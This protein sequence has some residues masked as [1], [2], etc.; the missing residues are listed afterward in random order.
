MAWVDALKAGACCLIVLHHLAFYG[1]MADQAS[2][3]WPGMF[4]WLAQHA[5]LA[6]Q[7]FL[8]LGGYLAARSLLP[9]L[10]NHGARSEHSG[11]RGLGDSFNHPRSP[12]AHHVSPWANAVERIAQRFIRLALPLWMALVAAVVCNAWADHWMDHPSIG[13]PPQGDQVLWHLLLL[14]DIA[15]HEALSAGVWYVAIDFQLYALLTL[16]AAAAQGTRQARTTLSVFCLLLLAVSAGWFNR[17]AH[18]D[19]FAPY[20]WTAYGLGVLLGLQAGPRTWV[21]AAVI[22]GVAVWWDPRL[23]LMVAAGTALVIGMAL[24]LQGRMPLSVAPWVQGLSR[25]SYSVFLIHFPI[26]LVVNA[27]WTAFLPPSPLVQFLGVITAFKLSLLAGWIFHHAV[28][29]PLVEAAT[30]LWR[31]PRSQVPSGSA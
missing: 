21:A 10:R 25:I 11:S 5:R 30:A 12:G 4:E 18:L 31:R 17:Q 13:A 27:A 8:V 2:A 19:E 9:A 3:L 16:M 22:V 23:R 26:S 14:Q 15:G 28:E 29:R 7:V 20:F 6:V 24:A 1:P